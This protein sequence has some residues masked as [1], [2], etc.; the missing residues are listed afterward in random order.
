MIHIVISV[1]VGGLSGLVV[2]IIFD[3]LNVN[4][5]EDIPTISLLNPDK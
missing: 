5:E 3:G 2:C 1:V 4:S